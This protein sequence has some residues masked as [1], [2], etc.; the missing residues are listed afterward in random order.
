MRCPKCDHPRTAGQTT[1]DGCGLV[2]HK[3]DAYLERQRQLGQSRTPPGPDRR[4]RLKA[5]LRG[6]AVPPDSL[7]RYPAAYALLWLG[8]AVWGG[9]QITQNLH[10]LGYQPSVLH[11]VNLPFHEAGHVVFGVFGRFIGSLGGTLGQL[12]IPVI[13]GIA[14]LRRPD[15]FGAAV[16]LWWF[17]QNFLDIAPYMA[18]ARAGQLPLVGGNY[19]RSSPYGFHD[20]EF[21]L[22]ETGLLAWDKALA[23]LTLNLGRLIMVASVAWAGLLVWRG[24]RG[25]A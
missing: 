14:L 12:L 16:C 21:L 24:R 7:R 19:G 13:C 3:Y 6:L 2:F 1:C 18:D 20:W 8:L 22:G 4:E 25:D 5:W 9:A 17:G 23:S 10:E 11:N 15:T